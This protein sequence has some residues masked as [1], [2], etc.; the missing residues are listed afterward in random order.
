MSC[1]SWTKKPSPGP[2][3]SYYIGDFDVSSYVFE[4]ISSLS[5]TLKLLGKT[6]TTA[7]K[8]TKSAEAAC[9]LS[10]DKEEKAADTSVG[11]QERNHQQDMKD[12]ITKALPPPRNIEF[13]SV[14]TD[15]VILSWDA[16]EGLAEQIEHFIV[17]WSDGRSQESR[18]VI[19]T[20]ETM[21]RGLSPGREYR[22]KVATVG[23]GGRQSACVSA[24][25]QTEV[26]APDRLTSTDRDARSLTISWTKPDELEKI[27]H[28]YLISST[29]PGK[30][31]FSTKSQET[32]FSNLDPDTLYTVEV[33]TILENGAQSDPTIKDFRT[34]RVVKKRPWEHIYEDEYDD[35]DDDEGK[36]H[37]YGDDDTEEQASQDCYSEST[38][39]Q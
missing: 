12:C 2:S 15:F 20:N 25:E 18:K 10:L 24:S 27:P 22:F 8:K 39:S 31:C 29:C 13:C 37:D 1:C 38:Y 19:G 26:P 32:T 21:I 9:D 14:G 33:S 36:E 4:G 28:H 3:S 5:I 30:G 16:P 7:I 17:T 6:S 11:L 35:D 23:E 34:A